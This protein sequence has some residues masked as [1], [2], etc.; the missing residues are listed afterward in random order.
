M[1]SLEVAF[2]RYLFTLIAIAIS[3]FLIMLRAPREARIQ[4]LARER[5]A[6]HTPATNDEEN[7]GTSWFR[8]PGWFQV[9]QH[10]LT[11]YPSIDD[12]SR[13]VQH[14]QDHYD[15]Q[16]GAKFADLWL[17]DQLTARY[18]IMRPMRHRVN[19]LT[20]LCHILDWAGEVDIDAVNASEVSE[21]SNMF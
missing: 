8:N 21:K 6:H 10:P 5:R 1:S 18:Q 3:F 13:R 7:L 15:Q 16:T 19:V 2:L 12:L 11:P 4:P 9:R 20:W 14:A 17:M